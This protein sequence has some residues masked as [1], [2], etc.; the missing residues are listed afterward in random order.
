MRTIVREQLFEKQLKRIEKDFERADQFIQGVEW[1]LCK[2][3]EAGYQVRDDSPVWGIAA[4]PDLT[5]EPVVVYYTFNDTHV[6]LLSIR[7]VAAN[8]D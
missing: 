4:Q 6:Y 2:N 1:V 8:G 7:A 3:P 5:A